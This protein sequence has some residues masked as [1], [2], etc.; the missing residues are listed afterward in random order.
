MS[1][2]PQE[3]SDD[4]EIDHFFQETS[5]TRSACDTQAQELV[6]GAISPVAVQGVCSYSVYADQV[7]NMWFNSD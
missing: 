4:E 2:T 6:G 1:A 5:T 3:Y 7:M